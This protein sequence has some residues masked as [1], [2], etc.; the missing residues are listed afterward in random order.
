M[1]VGFCLFWGKFAKKVKLFFFFIF[2]C[3]ASF[4]HKPFFWFYKKCGVI[5]QLVFKVNGG[6]ILHSNIIMIYH[7]CI[8]IYMYRLY[9]Q[10]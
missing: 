9:I 8:Y 10:I 7:I 1:V 6:V 3:F 4:A 2:N 5:L